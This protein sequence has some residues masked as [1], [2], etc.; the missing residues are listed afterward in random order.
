MPDRKR[1]CYWKSGSYNR[2]AAHPFMLDYYKELS[3]Q[4]GSFACGSPFER[5]CRL[6]YF[7][8]VLLKFTKQNVMI[9]DQGNGEE[10]KA[11]G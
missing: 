9:Y 3:S 4:L 1:T 5:K 11:L 2:T 10:P 6:N 7:R 8:T